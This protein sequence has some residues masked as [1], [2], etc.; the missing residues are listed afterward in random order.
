MNVTVVSASAGSLTPVNNHVALWE[1]WKDFCTRCG[2]ERALLF[3][4]WLLSL[5]IPSEK[6]L[7][8]GKWAWIRCLVGMAAFGFLIIQ[9]CVLSL[10]I[11][12]NGTVCI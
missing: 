10:F 1:K 2:D 6:W 7:R 5:V 8:S 3:K 9:P 12:F 4:T 11:S